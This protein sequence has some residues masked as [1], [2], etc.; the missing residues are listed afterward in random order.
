MPKIQKVTNDY[1]AYIESLKQY[2]I[3]SGENGYLM[4]R[5]DKTTG[6]VDTI[7]D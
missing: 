3:A 7:V 2:L 1:Y 5:E 6:V 4:A